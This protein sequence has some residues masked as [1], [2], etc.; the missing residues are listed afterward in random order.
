MRTR[1]AAQGNEVCESHLESAK[2]YPQKSAV[3]G[4]NSINLVLLVSQ[5]KYVIGPLWLGACRFLASK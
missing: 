4:F 5:Q 2:F 1:G 3:A